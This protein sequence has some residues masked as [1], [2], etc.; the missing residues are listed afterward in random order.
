MG[1]AFV[2][3]ADGAFTT[4]DVSGSSGTGSS[5]INPG[6]VVIGSYTLARGAHGFILDKKGT[7]VTFDPPG[8]E[9]PSSLTFPNGINPAGVVTGW[10]V[11]P[12]FLGHGFLR[13]P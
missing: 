6:G 9:E 1:H 11:D 7:L 2:R 4:F 5:D 8:S 13:I 12:S 3:S 10:Y